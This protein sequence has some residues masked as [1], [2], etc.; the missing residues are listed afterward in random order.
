MFWCITSGQKGDNDHIQESLHRIGRTGRFGRRN[1]A[2]NF[3]PVHIGFQVHVH[4]LEHSGPD[5]ST[6]SA[7]S[8]L[9]YRSVDRP[10]DAPGGSRI[11]V[12]Q[13]NHNAEESNMFQS[14]HCMQAA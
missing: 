2:I 13:L 3:V 14:L 12:L 9:R 5:D 8:G 6:A 7:D 11:V 1:V 10:T 4:L